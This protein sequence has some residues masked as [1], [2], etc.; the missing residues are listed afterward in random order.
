MGK[1]SRRVCKLQTAGTR[2]ILQVG[3]VFRVKSEKRGRDGGKMVDERINDDW[4]F[5]LN[6]RIDWSLIIGNVGRGTAEGERGGE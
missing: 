2:K 4:M 6:V 1:N 5:A 3:G